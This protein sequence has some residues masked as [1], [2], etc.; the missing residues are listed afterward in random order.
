MRALTVSLTDELGSF[1]DDLVADGRYQNQSEV[2]RAGLRLLMKDE[3][4]RDVAALLQE[5]DEAAKSGFETYDL[6]K[7]KTRFRVEA[8]DEKKTDTVVR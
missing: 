2:V 4:R 6:E 3:D 5:L 1:I 8:T 7:M